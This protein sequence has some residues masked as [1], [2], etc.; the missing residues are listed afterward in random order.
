MLHLACFISN[1]KGNLIHIQ[2]SKTKPHHKVPCC[3]YLSVRGELAYGTKQMR[4]RLMFR[5]LW[6]LL[7]AFDVATSCSWVENVILHFPGS[8][9]LFLKVCVTLAT[10]LHSHN[11]YDVYGK[12]ISP[13][14]S[15]VCIGLKLWAKRN[16]YVF[17]DR[18]MEEKRRKM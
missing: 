7:L 17:R 8:C 6:M 18:S 10:N 11:L 16:D 2:F 3:V 13:K 14:T 15:G 1:W 9:Y 12:G 4:Y 5:S